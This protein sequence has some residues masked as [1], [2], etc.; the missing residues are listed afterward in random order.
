MA[1]GNVILVSQAE[2]EEAGLEVIPPLINK[3]S[4]NL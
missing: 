1:E 3:I 2:G 4:K